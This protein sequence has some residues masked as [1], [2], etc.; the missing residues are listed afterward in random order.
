V[1]GSDAYKKR[2]AA[3][4]T[5]KN[6]RRAQ[7]RAAKKRPGRLKALLN[8]AIA[9]TKDYDGDAD[10]ELLRVHLL[11][12]ESTVPWVREEWEPYVKKLTRTKL[13]E[14]FTMTRYAHLADSVSPPEVARMLWN[15][16]VDHSIEYRGDDD[17][18]RLRAYLLGCKCNGAYLRGYWRDYVVGLERDALSIAVNPGKSGV[19]SFPAA[20]GPR[21]F[22]L[23]E[24]E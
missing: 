6:E 17:L 18:E 1:C 19:F 8:V 11:E 20:F 2:K 12:C 14:L 23:P 15:R 7:E 16:A 13:T 22:G 10:P 5:A 9:R 4:R 21:P 3:R 24:R